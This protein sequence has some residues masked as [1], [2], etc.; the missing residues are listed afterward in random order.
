MANQETRRSDFLAAWEQ[1]IASLTA[2]ADDVPHLE[3]PRLKLQEFLENARSLIQQQDF[4]DASKQAASQQLD[5][6]LVNGKKLATFLRTGIREHYGNRSVKLV[7]FGIQ[8]F[9]RRRAGEAQAPSPEPEQPE[10]ETP[11]VE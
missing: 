1:L 5:V 11:P 3:A 9:A 10:L 8:P 6:F 4:H 2:N 7:E